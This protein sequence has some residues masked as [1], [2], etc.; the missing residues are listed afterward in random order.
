MARKSAK[1]KPKI[2]GGD[3]PQPKFDEYNNVDMLDINKEV[4]S[5]QVQHGLRHYNMKYKSKDAKSW[6]LQYLKKEGV[7]TDKIK[8]VKQLEDWR[9]GMT[10]GSLAKMLMDG[11]PRLEK[12]TTG[13]NSHLEELLRMQGKK[14]VEEVANPTEVAPVLS[15]QER[16]KLNLYEFLGHNVEGE[17]DEF[18]NN[19]FKSKFKLIDTLRVNEITGKAAGMIPDLYAQEISDLTELL[20]PPKEPDDEF[21][22]LTEGYPYK[23][24]ELKKILAF[25]TMLA[26]DAEHHANAQ[27][28][29]RKTRVKKA[30]SLEKLV[31][32]LTYKVKDDAYKIVSIDPK[33]I[34]GAQEL[35]VF[36]TKTR[37][38]G[39]YVASNGFSA[40]E[41]TVKGASIVG[42]DENNSIQKTIRK[43]DVTLKEFQKAGK[44][45]L[46]KFLE[47]IKA[48]DIKLTGRINKEIVLL[49]VN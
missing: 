24:A 10:Y 4:L 17:I 34:I 45:A 32:K 26:E 28:A 3:Y 36:N 1:R 16:M 8:H 42:F 13:V 46:R 27:K 35:W 31:A 19:K 6:F 22:Q 43:P 37:K 15:I 23:K 2:T 7:D 38:L 47:D 40:G 12:Y 41:L 9:V 11:C 33:K 39:K 18:F 5:K 49:K 30:P 21:E 20:N 48:T 25:Y 44:V 14:V 29:T